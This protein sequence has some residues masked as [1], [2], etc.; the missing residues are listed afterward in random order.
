MPPK[1]DDTS[2]NGGV[3]EYDRSADADGDVE[4][5]PI[6]IHNRTDEV[7]VLQ[8]VAAQPASIEN[9]TGCTVLLMGATAQVTVDQCTNCNFYFGPVGGSR[10]TSPIEPSR[11]ERTA[12]STGSPR[13]VIRPR[14][15]PCW[16]G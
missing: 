14:F 5:E 1:A 13:A 4:V 12:L 15:D 3:F 9:L 2:S 11:G 10:K 8:T 6:S 16:R 7:V